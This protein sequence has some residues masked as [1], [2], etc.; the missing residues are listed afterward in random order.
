[1]LYFLVK[2][3]HNGTKFSILMKYTKKDIIIDKVCIIDA[4]LTLSS[5]ENISNNIL[6]YLLYLKNHNFK[7]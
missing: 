3:K 1:M 6:N 4:T 2:Y 5:D 7:L